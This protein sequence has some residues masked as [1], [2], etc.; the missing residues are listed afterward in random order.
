MEQKIM[1]LANI[2]AMAENDEKDAMIKGLFNGAKMELELNIKI[3]DKE[4]K[5]LTIGK[6]S[7]VSKNA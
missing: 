6:A 5:S 4:L 1:E 2:V 3:V 7:Y